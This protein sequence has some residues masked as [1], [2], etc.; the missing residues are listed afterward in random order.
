MGSW[1]WGSSLLMADLSFFL[2][3]FPF[4][5]IVLDLEP[6]IVVHFKDPFDFGI[7]MPQSIQSYLQ[8]IA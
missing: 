5:Q 8:Q 6:F 4:L 3:F 2:S 7:A 1:E